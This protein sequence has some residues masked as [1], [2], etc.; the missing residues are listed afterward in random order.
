MRPAC[1]GRFSEVPLDDFAIPRQED[2]LVRLEGVEVRFIGT[3][4][5]RDRRP[6]LLRV[7]SQD[8]IERQL[9]RVAAIAGLVDQEDV[10]PADGGWRAGHEL[11]RRTGL[12]P[13]ERHRGEIPLED[14]GDD[15]PGDHAGLRDPENDLGVRS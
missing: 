14:R 8:L 13:G 7:E 1:C 10:P 6:D 3:R 11:W 4:S 5:E 9:E 12:V 2:D 15:H